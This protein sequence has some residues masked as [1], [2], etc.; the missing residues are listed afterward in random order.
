MIILDTTE[1]MDK[2]ID[3]FKEAA[4]LTNH[5]WFDNYRI[6]LSTNGTLYGTQGVQAFIKK[7]ISHLS[8]G[9][10]VDGNK[11]LHDSHRV[12]VDGRG[13]YEDVIRNVPLWLSQ[14][15]NASTKATLSHDS[16]PY[17]KDSVISLWELGIKTIAMNTVFEDV[18]EEGDDRI[19][20][21]QLTKLG[22]YII[23]SGVWKNY[24]CTL[25]TETIGRPMSAQDNMNWCGSGKMLAVD[26][27]GQFFP[28]NRFTAFS[29]SRHKPRCIG[30]AF[31][32]ID[33]NKLRPFLALDRFSQ[34]S[35]ECYACAVGSGC[36]W[37][38]GYNYD[39]SE[40]GT[41]YSRTTFHCAMHKA[42]VRAV[43]AFWEKFEKRNE[44]VA[45]A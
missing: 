2:I 28:C 18:W 42:R 29:L 36:A 27:D 39:V 3:Y 19:F 22:D 6:S 24:N 31:I 25:F 17:V 20:E 43:R 7:H 35:D 11:E 8:I 5:P 34:S 12:Y 1:L 30:N 9:I 23:E 16:L 21:D 13:S 44:A 14:F 26:V 40:S 37:C 45:H 38:T 41:I 32:G 10:S 33:T 15:P 4:F